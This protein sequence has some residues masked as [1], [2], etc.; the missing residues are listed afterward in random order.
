MTIG[1][2]I[3]DIDEM[4]KYDRRPVELSKIKKK[5]TYF[6]TEDVELYS[7]IID[8]DLWIHIPRVDETVMLSSDNGDFIEYKVATVGSIV[9]TKRGTVDYYVTLYYAD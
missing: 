3:M 8:S 6:N 5:I 4:M 2:D 9:D 7:L 1:C